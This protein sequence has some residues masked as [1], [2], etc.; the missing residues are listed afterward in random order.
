MS[1][2]LEEKRVPKELLRLRVPIEKFHFTTTAE[3]VS[4]NRLIGQ[5][6]AA[7]AVSFGLSSIRRDTTYSW[8]AIRE[9]VV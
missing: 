8:W 5:E 3:L 6:R 7:K 4:D 9:A 2:L 1:S